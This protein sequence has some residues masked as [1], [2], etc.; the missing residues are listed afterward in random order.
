MRDSTRQIKINYTLR[1]TLFGVF[2]GFCFPL[3]ATILDVVV[4]GLPFSLAGV[5]QAQATQPLHWIMDSLFL[6]LF[7][8]VAGRQRNQ[9]VKIVAELDERVVERTF[10][11][12]RV[13]KRLER[14]V[15][16]RKRVEEERAKEQTLLRT[17]IDNLPDLIYVKDT[18]SRYVLSNSAHAA[19]LGVASPEAV[20]GK[21]VFD[22][23]S[24]ELAKQSRADDQTVMQSG[25]PL[26]NREERAIAQ[27]TGRP[28]WNLTT[29][30]PLCDDTGKI[31][32]LLGI[33]RD[34]TARKQAEEAFAKERNLLRTLIDAVPDYIFVKDIETRYLVNNA[35]H[36]RALN[37][38]NQ[39]DVLGKNAFDFYPREQAERLYADDLK[40]LQSGEP[41]LNKEEQR[42]DMGTG[43]EIWNLATKVPI[44]D[45][46]GHI[47][48]LVGA[49]RNITARK[50]AEADL[51]KQ[52]QFFE[53][54]VSNSP[55]AIVTLD[56][57]HCVTECNPAFEKLFGYTRDEVIGRELDALVTNEATRAEAG[58]Y[59]Q[60]VI[61]GGMV[62]GVGRRRRYDGTLVDVE[63]FGVPVIVAGQQVGVLALYHDITDLVQAREQAEAADRAKSAFLAAMSHEIRTPLNGVIGM[64]GLLLDTPLNAQQR[65]Y[66]ETIR[67]SGEN[68]LTI[69]ND[70]LDFSKIEAGRMELETTDFDLCQVIESIGAL[71][72][73][74]AYQKGLELIVS[75]DPNVPTALRG[76]PFRMGQVLT[77][78]I[79]NALKF[80]ERGEVALSVRL[81]ETKAR[82]VTLSFA[83]KDT[84]IGVSS[85]QQARLFKPFS[86]ADISTTRK[87]GGTGLGLAISK[88][89]VEIMGGQIMIDS[90]AGEGST[91]W[92][93]VQLEQGSP[94]ALTQ[95]V[96]AADLQ[97]VRVLIVDDNATNR[98]VLHHQ[99]IAWG[100]RP[101]S[102]SNAAEALEKLRGA[103]AS[104]P[105]D[106]ALLD[107]EMPG[108]DG[109]GLARAVRADPALQAIRLILLTSV[110]RIG[111][112]EAARKLGLDAAL[113]KPVRQSELYNCLITVLGVTAPVAGAGAPA[114]PRAP[115]E[116]GKGV[117]VLLA[118]DNVVNQQVAVFMLQA[119]GYQVEIVSNGSAAVDALA[120]AAHDIVL[121][122]CQMPEMDGFEATTAIRQREGSTRHTPIIA[123]TA[124]AL[125]GERDKCI[126]AG[127]DDYL[128]KPITPDVLY[129]TLRRWL[130]GSTA[131]AEP[132]PVAIPLNVT[133]PVPPA[134]VPPT[135]EEEPILDSAVLDNFRELQ[136]PGAPDIIAQLI[137]L[138]LG[139]LPQKLAAVHQ[140]I[141]FRDAA[142]LAK[143]AHTLKGSSAN[144]GAR[145]AARVC[146]E[147]ENLGKAGTLTGAVDWGARLEE[148]L[149]RVHAALLTVR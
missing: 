2:F 10:E 144:V 136:E 1:Y 54:L 41:I 68:L 118:E 51:A 60:Q 135:A 95:P 66:A 75:V 149:A 71:F 21:T 55:V 77:N 48:G 117:R 96:V 65:Q 73:E 59:T 128:A 16:E 45:D 53:S 70:I 80:T 120:R 4:R 18:E 58:A 38:Q 56:Q 101:G 63:I 113:V 7:A 12:A 69:I 17:L 79:G 46:Q 42:R 34:I 8:Y 104:A 19:F 103:A 6:G 81:L 11:L 111:G 50:Q 146:L 88:R 47:I 127:M 72:A 78:L 44:R 140:A 115:K 130:P 147:L 97:G 64:T 24:P 33:A 37:A 23:F 105:F 121:M 98:T 5:L 40:V 67:F 148:E 145:R 35:A 129:A 131:R 92:F 134:V 82:R 110:A 31:V 9:V 90:R 100:M 61:Q 28:V 27:S 20:V 133:A 119:R 107:M 89:L 126:A 52:K 123:L 125:R 138:F 137:D 91:F 29:K 74:R 132:M 83:V 30:V 139:E 102:A 112:D 93:T 84:G 32:G 108:M 124:H 76:D 87:Y 85:E 62:H 142:R 106:V 94:D 22:L 36:L 86:Q 15:A 122:D 141:E 114:L 43:Q 39:Q 57:D 26:V 14:D 49:G 143:A 3:I 13:N 109:V 25:Q 116:E 99:V